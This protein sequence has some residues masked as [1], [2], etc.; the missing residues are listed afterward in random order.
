MEAKLR[1]AMNSLGTR[2]LT[3]YRGRHL[4]V[5]CEDCELLKKIEADG[6]IAKH[7]DLDL[8]S[9]LLHIALEFDCQRIDNRFS[10][11]CQLHY[12]QSQS[13]AAASAVQASAAQSM[14]FSDLQEWHRLYA[15]CRGCGRRVPI[16]RWKLQRRL[17]KDAQLS[18]AAAYLI[19]KKCSAKGH[20]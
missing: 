9:L 2:T 20:G 16:D 17:G 18:E 4:V 1:T 11:R 12:H 10:A 7:G 6:L 8:P 15:G 19:C 5:A 13:E 14:R 3:D